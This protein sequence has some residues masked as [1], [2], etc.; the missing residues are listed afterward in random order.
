MM[1]IDCIGLAAGMGLGADGDATTAA[2]V[3]GE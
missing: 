3:A 1:A 2:T